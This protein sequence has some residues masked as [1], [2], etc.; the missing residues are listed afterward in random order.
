MATLHLHGGLTPWISDGTP[1]QWI[2]PAGEDT[3]YPVGVSVKNV[4]DMP[5]P[6]DGSMTFFYTNQQSARMLWIHDHSFGITRLNVYAGEAQAYMITD[7]AE[8]KLIEDE[9]IPSDQIP[10][11]IQDKTFV[12][13]A[14]ITQTDPTWN[15]GITPGT[16]RTGDLWVPHVYVPAQNPA[17]RDA[18]N[19]TGRWHYGPWF[20]PPVTNI[21]QAP[22]PNPYYDPINAPWEP[23]LM[24][25]TPNPSMGMENYNDT[26]MINGTAYPKLTVQPKSYRFR[27]LNAANDRFFNLQMYVADGIR[28]ELRWSQEHRGQDGAGGCDSRLPRAVADRW[29]HRWSSRPQDR[30]SRVGPD[31]Y[32]ERL[33]AQARSSSPTSPSRGTST[34]P[35]STWAT[36]RTTA[37]FSATPS[38]L[39]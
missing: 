33:P 1:H 11:V 23:A 38:A 14:T 6:G 35:C 18:I 27:I 28:H 4:P 37:C 3:T 8:K 9:V 21:R 22:I 24:P 26:P 10:L 19:P 2:T 30:R 20:W 5:D 25:A 7:D 29:S 39:T 15:W 12:D 36:C 13:A 31:R 34:R 16:P 17:M 32:R